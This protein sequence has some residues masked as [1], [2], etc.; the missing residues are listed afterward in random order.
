ALA[1]YRLGY[2]VGPEPVMKAVRKI[3]NHTVYNVPDVLQRAAARLLDDPASDE[4]LAG[5]RRTYLAARD[6]AAGLVSAPHHLPEGA[7]Y[8]FID[9]SRYVGEGSEAIWPL[10]E[11]LLDAGVSVSP[12]EQF[13]KGFERH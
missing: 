5:A 9:L 3:A 10:I 4:W 8:L 13:G 1:G 12:G 2:A 7:T 11:Q 6:L